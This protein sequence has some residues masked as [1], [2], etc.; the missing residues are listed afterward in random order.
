MRKAWVAPLKPEPFFDVLSGVQESRRGNIA[1]EICPSALT[2]V[3]HSVLDSDDSSTD[4]SYQTSDKSLP[5]FIDEDGMAIGG[6]H[7]S[8]MK[9]PIASGIQSVVYR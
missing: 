7:V 6:L 5:P 8:I 3:N 9:P 1:S 2:S 4:E